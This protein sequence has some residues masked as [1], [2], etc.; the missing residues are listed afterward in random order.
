MSPRAMR[1]RVMLRIRSDVKNKG[2]GGCKPLIVLLRVLTTLLIVRR[3]DNASNLRTRFRPLSWPSP[4]ALL[5]PELEAFVFSRVDHHPN[6]VPGLDHSSKLVPGLEH[7]L[8]PAPMLSASTHGI[9]AL[10][11]LKV[12]A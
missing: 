2:G 10:F 7:S 6:I 8:G 4:K 12:F 9:I 11:W 3:F 5:C 1:H